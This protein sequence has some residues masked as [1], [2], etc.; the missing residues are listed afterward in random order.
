MNVNRRSWIAAALSAP[1]LLGSALSQAAE[2]NSQQN[3]MA[4]CNKEAAGKTGDERKAFMSEC[5]K[6]KPAAA[7]TQ[8]DRMKRCNHEATGKSGDERKAFMS[9]C[10]KKN[11]G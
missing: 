11:A 3:R 7:E 9:Q 4:A 5:L 8:Q 1:L 2:P 6:N 10:L